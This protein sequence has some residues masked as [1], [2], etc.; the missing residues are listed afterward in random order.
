M[1]KLEAA[2]DCSENNT[3]EKAECLFMCL[4]LQYITNGRRLKRCIDAVGY[5][6]FRNR[7]TLVSTEKIAFVTVIK[8]YILLWLPLQKSQY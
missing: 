5:H 8:V 1:H 2:G 6:L 3:E 4:V 7:P